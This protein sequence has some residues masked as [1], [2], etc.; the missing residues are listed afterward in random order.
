MTMTCIIMLFCAFINRLI[1]PDMLMLFLL[2]GHT[3][4]FPLLLLP[5]LFSMLLLLR[6]I[7]LLCNMIFCS[8]GLPVVMALNDCGVSD[9]CFYLLSIVLILWLTLF[10]DSLSLLFVAFLLV[11]VPV[12][13][14]VTWFFMISPVFT[15]L[16]AFFEFL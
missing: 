10:Q 16:L 13:I 5:L 8:L 1:L 12:F 4:L 15:D 14:L 7:P 11:A 3:L 6:A 2:F 9:M